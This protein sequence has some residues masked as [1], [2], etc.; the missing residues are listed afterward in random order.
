MNIRT[1]GNVRKI[2][3]EISNDDAVQVA[4]LAVWEPGKRLLIADA[5]EA[6]ENKIDIKSSSTRDRISVLVM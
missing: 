1:D 3:S 2:F 4:K 6:K 5:E